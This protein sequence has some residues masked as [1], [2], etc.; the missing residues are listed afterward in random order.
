V[1]DDHVTE[2]GR[3]L[4]DARA[5]LIAARLDTA[6]WRAQAKTWEDN[7]GQAVELANREL[8]KRQEAYAKL[9]ILMGEYRRIALAL[10]EVAGHGLVADDVAAITGR[11]LERLQREI[12]KLEAGSGSG[13]AD[14]VDAGMA[15]GGAG[16]P[17][18]SHT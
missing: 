15:A 2:A 8:R 3:E 9:D 10:A 16:D 14:A 13:S 4:N 5:A 17:R 7:A 6:Q 18:R 1:S 12:G 11:F